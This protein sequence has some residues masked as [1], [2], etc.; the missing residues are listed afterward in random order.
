MFCSFGE[1]AHASKSR[2]T[3][4]FVLG[5]QLLNKIIILSYLLASLAIAAVLILSWAY[6]LTNYDVNGQ[7]PRLVLGFSGIIFANIAVRT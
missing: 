1:K 4:A 7:C 3:N 5:V 2:Y 6:N